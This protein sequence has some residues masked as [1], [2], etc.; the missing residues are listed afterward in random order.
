MRKDLKINLALFIIST[1]LVLVFFELGARYLYKPKNLNYSQ[2]IQRSNNP[3]IKWEHKPNISVKVNNENFKIT[4]DKWKFRRE[5]NNISKIK[6]G[7]KKRVLL[8]GDSVV[9]GHGVNDAETFSSIMENID[10]DI[11]VLNAA[12]GGYNTFQ[13]KEYLI[14]EG[15]Q[16]NPDIVILG[17]C[18]N[19]ISSGYEILSNFHTGEIMKFQNGFFPS[20]LGEVYKE[21]IKEYKNFN[22]WVYF[23]IFS[24]KILSD[25]FYS[26]K[27]KFDLTELKEPKSRDYGGLSRLQAMSNIQSVEFNWFSKQ[28][29][30]I[31]N[32]SIDHGFN[33]LVLIFPLRSQVYF[34]EDERYRPIAQEKM[35]VF[36]K[37]K[38]IKYLDAMEV[39]NSPD[40]FLDNTHL[41]ITGHQ[42][43]A[44]WL[45]NKI[46]QFN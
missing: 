12:V 15:I 32:F 41:S 44:T 46:F 37:N 40:D 21:P 35:K 34:D 45:F 25:G 7:N 22:E 10:D 39:I 30:D 26:A 9:E 33:F 6:P 20:I 17:F 5:E 16:F 28:I 8:I 2:F 23:N 36:F 18:F 43:I 27:I 24:Y 29:I 14:T 38:N 1:S 3:N 42:K 13:E 19:D 11:Q 4:T 31:N